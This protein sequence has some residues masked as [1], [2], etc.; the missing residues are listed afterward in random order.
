MSESEK[1]EVLDFTWYKMLN[2][3]C[4]PN[5]TD[6]GRTYVMIVPGGLWMRFHGGETSSSIAAGNLPSIST[7]FVPCEIHSY[8]ENGKISIKYGGTLVVG[9]AN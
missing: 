6:G 4:N 8:R 3:G 1:I 5:N 9:P 7:V 2:S